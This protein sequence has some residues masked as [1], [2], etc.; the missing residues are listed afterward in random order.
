MSKAFRLAHLEEDTLLRLGSDTRALGV[1]GFSRPPPPTGDP[2]TFVDSWGVTWRR[3]EYP[4]GYYWELHGHP[5]AEATV[6]DLERYPW[7][8]PLDPALTAGLAEEVRALRAGPYAHRGRR[9][10]QELLGAGIHAARAGAV[11][12]GPGGESGVRDRP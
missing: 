10:L 12:R 9:R 4:G 11:P 8:D 5:L 6:D 7:P 3:A 1:K 2:S